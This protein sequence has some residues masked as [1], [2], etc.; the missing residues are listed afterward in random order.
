[1]NNTMHVGDFTIERIIEGQIPLMPAT[2][3]FKSLTTE[4]LEENRPWLEP[5]SLTADGAIRVA[6]QSFL[7][8][9]PHHTVL[10]DTCIGND[11]PR[12]RPDWHMKSDTTYM[13]GLAAAGVSVDQIDFVFCTHMHV[14]HVGWN[15]R[16]QDGRWVPTFPNARYIFAKDEYAY[17]QGQ[18]AK[19]ENP[20]FMDSVLPIVEAGRAEMVDSEF[21][22]GDH[23]RLMPTPGHTPGHVSVALGHRGEAVVSGD[24]IHSPLQ[25]RYPE[26]SPVFDVDLGQA[27]TT[28]RNF[29]EAYAET[30]KLCCFTHF[31]SRAFSS[32][33]RW[34]DG[35]RCEAP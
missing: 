18:N 17:W 32:V 21:G 12:T 2:D 5:D 13:E 31:T 20:V 14:D 23:F 11:K 34:G 3:M 27:A 4:M 28:R 8:R 9:T 24:L 29:L 1:M 26:L 19:T 30:D 35:F 6:F 25:A 22:F 7:V 16:L 33:K 15:T 10:I